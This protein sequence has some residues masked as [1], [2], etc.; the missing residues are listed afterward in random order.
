MAPFS[1]GAIDTIH[2]STR[3]FAIFIE[4]AS[5]TFASRLAFV[6]RSRITATNANGA[7]TLAF[8]RARCV[9]SSWTHHF[10]HDDRRSNKDCRFEHAK[11]RFRKV[12]TTGFTAA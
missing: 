12:R 8:G 4:L 7:P 6:L 11:S 10:E 9:S 2:F 1:S 3:F 5:V